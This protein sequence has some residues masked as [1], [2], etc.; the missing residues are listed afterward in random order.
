MTARGR[1]SLP[2]RNGGRIAGCAIYPSLSKIA[3]SVIAIAKGE[4]V[5]ILD[6]GPIWKMLGYS[7]NGMPATGIGSEFKWF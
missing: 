4:V 7:G 5:R 6:F 2:Q 1:S 3:D